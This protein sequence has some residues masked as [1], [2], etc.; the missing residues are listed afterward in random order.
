MNIL[1]V[2]FNQV[3]GLSVVKDESGEHV[4]LD[5]TERHLNHVGTIHAAALFSLAESASGHALL[6]R[7]G[8]DPNRTLA[9]LRSASVKISKAGGGAFSCA[10]E[11]WRSADAKAQG[12]VVDEG[13]VVH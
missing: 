3:V 6:T 12:P 8:L 4:C 7:T 9:L 2:P 13:S 5:P 1:D 11:R 10:G